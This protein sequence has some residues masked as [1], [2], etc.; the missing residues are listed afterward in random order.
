[1]APLPN[2]D[3]HHRVAS[4]FWKVVAVHD[5]T[6]LHVVAFTMEQVTTR[7][8]RAIDHL[9]TVDE[10]ERHSGLNFFWQLPDAEEKYCGGRHESGVG[11][12]LDGLAAATQATLHYRSA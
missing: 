9:T 6:A 1:M 10:V 8:S 2:Y 5:G 12:E 4:G 7:K 3:E 11:A